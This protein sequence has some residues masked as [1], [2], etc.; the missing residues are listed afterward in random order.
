MTLEKRTDDYGK[1]SSVLLACP[2][3]GEELGES[4]RLDRHLPCEA[5]PPTE[6]FEE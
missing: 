4:Y 3:C 5:V 2:Y 1:R 6:G